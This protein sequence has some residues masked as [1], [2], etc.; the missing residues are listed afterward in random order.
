MIF[1]S[2]Q[3][4]AQ[5]PQCERVFQ[6]KPLNLKDIT[7]F[8]MHK[9][10]AESGDA[11]SQYILAIL[12]EEGQQ[13]AQDFKKAAYWYK[14]AA[15][16]GIDDAQLKIALFYLEGRG[17]APNAKKAIQWLE[18]AVEKKNLNAMFRLG[19]LYQY[20]LGVKQDVEKALELFVFA[21]E[22]GHV[23]TQIHLGNSYLSGTRG[24][25]QDLL[26][27]SYWIHKAAEQGDRDTQYSLGVAHSLHNHIVPLNVNKHIEWLKKAADQGHEEAQLDLGKLFFTGRSKSNILEAP[28]REK[29]ALHF[30]RLAAKQGNAEAQYHIGMLYSFD[31]KAVLQHNEKS[32]FWLQKSADQRHSKAL[33]ELAIRYR[34]GLKTQKDTQKS[35]KLLR[36]LLSMSSQEEKMVIISHYKKFVHLHQ[37]NPEP[38]EIFH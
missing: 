24:L 3:A 27:S 22:L 29:L 4:Q 21:G 13:T 30:F 18:T 28:K 31:N 25:K 12:F 36:K 6:G 2:L 10:A 15:E 20:G 23:K 11:Y 16:Q 5:K 9:K 14:K 32:M 8:E 26:K 17:V 34:T 35:H 1:I 33:L 19:T 38:Q 7:N 37:N